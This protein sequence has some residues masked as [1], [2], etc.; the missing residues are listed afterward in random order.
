M[1]KRP[2]SYDLLKSKKVLPIALFLS[3]YLLLLEI[4]SS[5][6]LAF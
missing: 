2:L 5:L 3:R 1:M 6:L 4:P